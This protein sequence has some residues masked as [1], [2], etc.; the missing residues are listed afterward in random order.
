MVLTWRV[1]GQRSGSDSKPKQMRRAHLR[2]INAWS[3]LTRS[4]RVGWNRPTLDVVRALE[5][6]EG[7]GELFSSFGSG[8]DEYPDSEVHQVGLRWPREVLAT[9]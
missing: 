4:Q 7:S 8:L 9:N 2:Y 3:S 5:V 6:I 1:R